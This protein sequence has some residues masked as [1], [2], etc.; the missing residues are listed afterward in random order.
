MAPKTART[1]PAPS[2]VRYFYWILIAVALVGIAVL[3]WTVVR[4]RV[5]GSAAVE[6]VNMD[7]TNLRAIYAKAVPQTVGQPTAPVKMVVFSDYM[8]PY[9]GEWAAQVQPRLIEDYVKPGKL[10]IVYYDFPLGGAHKYS[11]LAARA[12]RCA[13][14][15]GKFWDMH[16]YIFGRQS[17]WSFQGTTP[18]KTFEGYA[19]AVGLDDARF[20]ACLESEKYADIVTANHMLGEKLGVDATPTVIINEK[21]INDPIKYDLLQQVIAQSGGAPAAGQP[22]AAP[23]AGA[24]PTATPAAPA[25]GSAQ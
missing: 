9:C 18:V 14:E 4:A 6:P 15:Q 12:A 17:E 3:V 21:K 23:A 5:G 1:A 20:N 8:C 16:D 2:P 11:F 10:Q 24:Q 25:T 13:G 19:K 22:G 7:S